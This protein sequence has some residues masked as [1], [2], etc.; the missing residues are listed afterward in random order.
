MTSLNPVQTVGAQVM[1]GDPAA[2]ATS[3]ARL[4]AAACS[5]C[6]RWS[7]SPTQ[8]PLRRLSAPALG[9]AQAARDDRDGAGDAAEA[10]DRRRADHGA[11]RDDP[12][13]DPRAAARL[14]AKTGTA[15]LL[16]THDLGVVNEVADRVAVMYAGR[17][18]RRA[19]AR[20]CWAHR[21][22]PTRRA[23]CAR[24]PRP[25]RGASGSR[26]SRAW[27]RAGPV[28][29]GLPL[30]PALPSRVR[31]LRDRGARRARS[32]R[33]RSRRAATWW[34]SRSGRRGHDRAQRRRAARDPGPAHL[35]P[36]PH[37]RACSA[38]AATCARW[39]ASTSRSS[40]GETLALVGESGC[41]KTT[42]GRSILRLV[43][44]TG[45]NVWFRGRT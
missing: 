41:G 26:R 2:R 36:D 45:G 10:A 23:C 34:R 22:I 16:I 29:A 15:M 11:R 28:A 13:A 18:S 39:T 38:S 20:S 30:P 8:E 21:A 9:R 32:C 14:S 31:A 35:V 27:C 17:S 3:P 1:R 37:G 33:R 7:A 12:G 6:S 44:P 25:R 42:V 4:R 5:S 19:R 24:S 43:E 40:R